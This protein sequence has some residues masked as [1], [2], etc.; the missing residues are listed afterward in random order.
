MNE[1]YE[2]ANEIMTDVYDMMGAKFWI[3]IDLA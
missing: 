2:L 1:N 3:I